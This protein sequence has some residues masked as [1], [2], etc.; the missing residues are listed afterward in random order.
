MCRKQFRE[1][2]SITPKLN[3]KFLQNRMYQLTCGH[4]L[5]C[6]R[7]FIQTRGIDKINDV[8]FIPS[9]GC[10]KNVMV[11]VK[12]TVQ[13]RTKHHPE[14]EPEVLAKSYVPIDVRTPISLQET[15]HSNKRHQQ[16]KRCDIHSFKWMLQKC[17][18]ACEE[19][20]L[21]KSQSSH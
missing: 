20:R 3:R 6:K 14:I 16:N 1:E 12:K 2:P 4:Q 9:N 5:V 19:N 17:N 15:F 13:G 11:H 21:R 10:F 18:G 7:H 8:I